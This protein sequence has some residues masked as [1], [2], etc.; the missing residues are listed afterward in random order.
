MSGTKIEFRA[1]R[2]ASTI[3]LWLF[4][5]A[6][7]MLFISSMWLYVLMRLGVFGRISKAPVHVPSLAWGSTVVLWIGSFT[8]HRA[9]AAIRRERLKSCLKFLYLTCALAVVFLAVQS[10]CMA[11]VL[12]RHRAIAEQAAAG[13]GPGEF[14]PVSMYGLVFFLILV[15]AL[16]VVGGI[17]ALA[18]VTLRARRGKYDHENYLGIQFAARYWHFLDVVWM[19]MFTMFLVMG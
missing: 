10:P 2:R 6:L 12:Q 3:G 16:H 18:I 1:P 14:A 15:H 19:A 5:A 11:Q 17:V 13:K 8:I 4:L 9:V 7:A